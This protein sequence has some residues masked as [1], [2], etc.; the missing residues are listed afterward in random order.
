MLKNNTLY[1]TDSFFS[2]LLVE[3]EKLTIKNVKE[4][5]LN[6]EIVNKL[7][8]LLSSGVCNLAHRCVSVY[9]DAIIINGNVYN[10]CLSCGDYFINNEH[11]YICNEEKIKDLLETFKQWD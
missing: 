6:E 7:E 9:R 11:R 8:S 10:I 2:G 5:L 4:V 3:D 1:Y